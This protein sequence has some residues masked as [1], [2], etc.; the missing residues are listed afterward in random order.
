M[1]VLC[2]LFGHKF[3]EG[4]AGSRSGYFGAIVVNYKRC[5]RCDKTEYEYSTDI[6][7]KPIEDIYN[8]RRL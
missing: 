2:R 6:S 8:T 5:E 3:R 4:W 1:I 7:M